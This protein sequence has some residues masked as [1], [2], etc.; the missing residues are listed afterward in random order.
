MFINLTDNLRHFC[1]HILESIGE[2][3]K[4]RG[5]YTHTHIHSQRLS[6]ENEGVREEKG[7]ERVE[8]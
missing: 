5:S 2:Q 3:C 6:L 7:V 1:K 4:E 8:T